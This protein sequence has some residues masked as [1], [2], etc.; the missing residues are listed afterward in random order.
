MIDDILMRVYHAV[1]PGGRVLIPDLYVEDAPAHPSLRAAWFGLHVPGGA[2]HSMRRMA[3]AVARA[4]FKSVRAGR[5]PN[6]IVMN[7][8][9]EGRRP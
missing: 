6:A 2:N 4:G 7:G 5:L 9:V 3:V 8:I 1:V